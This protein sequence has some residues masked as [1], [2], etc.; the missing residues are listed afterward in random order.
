MDWE[1]TKRIFIYLLIW[2]NIGLFAA[3]HFNGH[4]YKITNER[5]SAIYKVLEKNGVGLYTEIIKEAP[6]MRE[7]AISVNALEIDDFREIF[8]KGE[9]PK[10][11]LEFDKTILASNTKSLI[12]QDNSIT[13]L[14]PNGNG[15]IENF[16]KETAMA[17]A[18]DFLE[19]LNIDGRSSL[20][21]ESAI[22]DNGA[23]VFEY[24]ESFR[25][26]KIF[27]SLKKI[28]V[29]EN[30]VTM[31][32]ASYYTAQEFTGEKREIYSCDEI[33]LTFLEEIRKSSPHDSVYIEKIELGYDF[34]NAKDIDDGSRLRLVPCYRIFVAGS[35][36]AYTINAYTN[37]LKEE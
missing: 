14:N 33:L 27:S 15:K 18:E 35:P 17:A 23:Y 30:G 25:G 9:N 37:E 5:E 13:Y 20:K 4:D 6:P 11:T 12:V 29:S 8:F 36:D 26:Y 31:A 7:L 24:M 16:G 21:L 2:L 19:L 32:S 34:K 22:P 10:I 1:K 28:T 3:N